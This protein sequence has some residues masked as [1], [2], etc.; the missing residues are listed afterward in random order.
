MQDIEAD[1]VDVV[2]VYKTDRLTR[3]PFDV[4][5]RELKAA[6]KVLSEWPEEAF[7]TLQL[8]AELGPVNAL[9]IEAEF[10]HVTEV[11]SGFGKLGVPAER[12]TQTAARRMA[13]YLASRAFAGPYFQDHL[14]LLF[15]MADQGAFTKVKLSEHTRTAADLIMR[16]TKR[17]LRVSDG[18]EGSH[19]LELA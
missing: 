3:I 8:P 17:E 15:A 14:L 4:A 12:L 2:M 7:T 19:L 5:D 9:L 11:M 1:E 6:R 16:F 13:G 10:E 18:D